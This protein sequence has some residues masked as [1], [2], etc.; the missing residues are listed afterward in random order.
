MIPL[1]D[2]LLS[3]AASAALKCITPEWNQLDTR[4]YEAEFL[5]ELCR[6]GLIEFQFIGQ[7]VVRLT[8]AG[9]SMNPMVNN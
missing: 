2:G 5:N 8:K 4:V 3:T 7:R 9:V 1:K 6:A